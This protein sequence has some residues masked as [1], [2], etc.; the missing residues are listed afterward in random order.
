[1]KR[2]KWL[3]IIVLIVLF[4]NI[5]F[6]IVVNLTKIDNIIKEKATQTLAA[7]LEAEVNIEDFRFNDKHLKVSNFVVHKEDEYDLI[8]DQIYI[9]YNLIKLLFS[10]F[11]DLKSIKKIK[12]YNPD[13]DFKFKKSDSQK[14]GAG[15]EIPDISRFFTR[16]EVYSGKVSIQYKNNEIE[17]ENTLDSIDVSI[18]NTDIS[19]IELSCSSS[20][21]CKISS[22]VILDRGKILLGNLQINKFSFHKLNLPKID[23]LNMNFNLNLHYKNNI[24]QYNGSIDDI[25]MNS[26]SKKLTADKLE[27]NGNKSFTA[28]N[29]NDL[30]VDKEKIDCYAKIL[31][32]FSKDRK[33]EGKINLKDVEF[34]KYFKSVKGRV[35]SQMEIEGLVSNPTINAKIISDQLGYNSQKLDKIK[36][37]AKYYDKVVNFELV[38]SYWE[39]NQ[40]IGGGIYSLEHGLDLDLLCDSCKWQNRSIEIAGNIKANIKYDDKIDSELQIDDLQVS[41]GKSKLEDLS[42]KSTYIDDQFSINLTREEDDLIISSYGSIEDINSEVYFQRFDLNKI[43]QSG[44]QLPVLSGKINIK[45]KDGKIEADSRL[46]TFG[47]E[48]GRLDGIFEIELLSDQKGDSTY[49][50]VGSNN[51]K[52]NYEPFQIDFV[53]AGSFDSVKTQRFTINDEIEIDSWLTFRPELNYGVKIHGKN[54]LLKNI[55]RY[56]TNYYVTSKI[57]GNM[58][59]DIDYDNSGDGNLNG[60][61]KIE[62]FRSEG[63]NDI[64][65][66]LNIN[67]DNQKIEFKNC[68]LNSDEGKLLEFSNI[69]TFKP[70]FDMQFSSKLDSLQLEELFSQAEIE[71]IVNGDI[72]Y[73][74]TSMNNLIDLNLIGEKI[75][76]DQLKLD[77]IKVNATQQ[78]SSLIIKKFQVQ[79][80][81]L[82]QMNV[83][84][85]I[86]Y[87]ILNSSFH[88][89]TNLVN[90]NFS[91]DPLKML[92]KLNEDLSDGSSDCQINLDLG[93]E[94]GGLSFSQGLINLENGK[95]KIKDQTNS[96]EDFD[97]IAKFNDNIFQLEKFRAKI[98]NGKLYLKNS[99]SNKKNNFQL[100]LLNLGTFQ[101]RTNKSG[102]LVNIPKFTPKNSFTQI[103]IKGRNSDHLKILGPF[104]DIKILG[105]VHCS[106]GNVIYPPETENLIKLFNVVTE[107]KK[108]KADNI[109]LPLNLDILL[110]FNENIRYVTYPANIELDP[111][112]HLHLKYVDGEF[113]VPSALFTAE[114]G[115]AN[116]FGTELQ[117]DFMQV[118]MNQFER[119]AKISGTFFKKAADGTTITLEIFNARSDQN[120]GLQFELKSDNPNDKFTDI[121]AKLRYNRTMDEIS[122]GQRKTLMQDEFIQ[123]AGIG[124]ESAVL[125]PLISPIENWVR[126]LLTLDYF[127]VKTD[128]VQNIFSSYS[129]QT[130]ELSISE[131][132]NT[133]NQFTADVFLNNL[134][135][136][137]G[138]YINHKLFANYKILFEKPTELIIQTDLG[139]YHQFS[140]RY[141]LPKQF[142][143]SYHYDILPFDRDDS[144]EIMLEKS[145]RFGNFIKFFE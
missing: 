2:K 3:I 112:C 93:I 139:I 116:M 108:K 103:A 90:I 25:M 123:I 44:N 10:K 72:S 69:I 71:G 83:A 43:F 66:V 26:Y 78:D 107:K 136:Q 75:Q 86:G 74:R 42:L 38:H 29:F 88:P 135:I 97:L 105:D 140:I 8:I 63:L 109:I 28:F 119:G 110:H 32:P 77:N 124:L 113:N 12:I 68:S 30:I 19:E 33:I 58:D 143:V 48:F 47:K 24:L 40:I 1:M 37:D 94:E 41:N 9:E 6:Y 54:I 36:V 142:N 53:A 111:D 141:D 31:S 114:N 84:G 92:T 18:K 11:K 64:D 20:N 81:D 51:A 133:L 76:I 57:K 23:S 87:N 91:G 62:D 100:G 137:A 73:K 55:L 82:F 14:E 16:L 89:D 39:D 127:H 50:S 121:L 130:E 70:E 128:L 80:Q 98:G 120:S 126:K 79:T 145:L 122:Q 34:S 106:N 52:Y 132:E 129:S 46:R 45:R 27:F 35:S 22:D 102:F 59:L 85:K 21:D 95:L 144:H 134:T 131:A 56:F 61:I 5:S 60:F 13:L 15:F 17:I 101:M 65:A 115:S 49:F 4:I 99:T 104:E 125:S 96:I 118:Q 117:L 138:K 7:Q 67:G